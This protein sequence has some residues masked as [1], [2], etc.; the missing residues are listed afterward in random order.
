MP[1]QHSNRD[2]KHAGVKQFLADTLDRSCDHISK[3]GDQSSSKKPGS[4]AH[5][6]G[7]VA[8]FYAVTGRKHD[9]DHQSGFQN[10]TKNDYC[11]GVH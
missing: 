2:Q 4:G 5:N 6:Y 3:G 10:F 9:A 8:T 1:G 7:E 11:S